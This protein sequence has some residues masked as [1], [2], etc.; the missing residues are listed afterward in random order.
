MFFSKSNE[1][2]EILAALEI[3]EKYVN[4][5]INSIPEIKNILSAERKIILDKID[6]ISKNIKEK[7]VSNIKVFGEIMLSLEKLSDGILDDRVVSQTENKNINYIGKSFNLMLD[8][9]DNTFDEVI[10][11]LNEYKNQNYLNKVNV[12]SFRDGKL[13]V[14]LEGINQLRD[15]ISKNLSQNHRRGL[16][17]E[18]SSTVLTENAS[19]L[20][21]QSTNQAAKIEELSAT[22]DEITQKVKENTNSAVTMLNNVSN[23][24]EQVH[25]GF[26]LAKKTSQSIEE[27]NS[28]TNDVNSAI[29]I[30]SQIAF[31]TNILSLNAAVEAATAGE[32]GK[33]FAVVAQEV[34]NLANKSAESAKQ[35]ESLM[36]DLKSKT[37]HGKQIIEQ[38]TAGY[39]QLNENIK[40]NFIHVKKVV[41]SLKEQ[42][43]GISIINEAISDIDRNTQNQALVSVKVNEIATQSQNVAKQI[44]SVTS[45]S[46]FEGKEQISIRDLNKNHD[47]YDGNCR[48]NR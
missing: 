42:E 46:S 43:E 7:D 2:Q 11:V 30:I 24:E 27:I 6:K 16:I 36:N 48:R 18:N 23:N 12:D 1:Y 10:N 5:D 37:E 13:R 26:E 35:I 25:H 4:K 41:D 28:S 33:G 45:N 31:Q 47:N 9:L 32:A 44:V 8:K 20:S 3:L 15:E 40:E 14:V 21:N 17:L 39:K 29:V 19:N 34:R 22:L 38:M